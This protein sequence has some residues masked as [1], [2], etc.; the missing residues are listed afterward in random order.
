MENSMVQVAFT[1]AQGDVQTVDV[2]AGAT[3]LDAAR[4]G[5]VAGIIGDCGGFCNCATCHVYVD[6]RWYAQLPAVEE[7]EDAMLDG[8]V[9][10]RLPTSR[11][12]CQ[13]VLTPE[14]D[15]LAVTL[16]EFQSL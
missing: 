8:T 12:S 2:D 1:S 16:P 3:L 4:N 13:V 7:H 11:L 6:E 9:C 14:L 15:G 10:D 5:G